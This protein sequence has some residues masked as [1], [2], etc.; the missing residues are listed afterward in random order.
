MTDQAQAQWT[1][2]SI[3]AFLHQHS[4]ELRAMGVVKIGVVQIRQ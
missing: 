4:A 2:D 3:L 1:A